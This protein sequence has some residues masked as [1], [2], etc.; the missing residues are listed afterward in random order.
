MRWKEVNWDGL[1]FAIVRYV[2]QSPGTT[3]PAVA[4]GID[5]TIPI[6]TIRNRVARLAAHGAIQMDRVLGRYYVLSPGA[7]LEAV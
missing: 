4:R 7:G 6:N 5:V 2:E 3:I 1:D